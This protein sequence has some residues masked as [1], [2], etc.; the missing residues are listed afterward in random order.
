MS[1]S[2]NP[3]E[4]LMAFTHHTLWRLWLLVIAM[5]A[6]YAPWFYVF[7]AAWYGQS[8][9]DWQTWHLIPLFAVARMVLATTS[10]GAASA[11]VIAGFSVLWRWSSGGSSSK[12]PFFAIR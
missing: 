6:A 4:L 7:P 8:I 1:Q 11:I 10:F 5:T 2:V 12:P 3:F 9:A